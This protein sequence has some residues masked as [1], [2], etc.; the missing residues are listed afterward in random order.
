MNPIL[1]VMTFVSFVLTMAVR[2]GAQA[3]VTTLLGDG[4]PAK[5]RR[6][7][8]NPARHMAAL[9]TF[10]ALALSFPLSG[11]PAGLGWG[12]P[13]KLDVHKFSVRANT[14]LILVALTGI[15]V[16]IILGIVIAVG[17]GF[18]PLT[19]ANQHT[20]INC[21]GLQGGPFQGCLQAWQPGWA[22]RL[23][24]FAFVFASVNILVGLLNIIPLYPLDGAKILFALLP[25]RQAISYRNSEANQEL[26]LFGIVLILPF[27]F[28]FA[29]IPAS[30][31]PSAL[32]QTLSLKI[33]ALFTSYFEPIV[34][35]L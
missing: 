31:A 3:M 23:E 11:I 7:T 10:V 13:I 30:F 21:F 9:G 35:N 2:Y 18:I 24:Q 17:L 20:I 12:K 8:L 5:E 27:L 33:M 32:L 1:I 15:A 6:L 28:A 34:E 26:I 16:N 25:D 22:L 29:R 4:T 19:I 14:G